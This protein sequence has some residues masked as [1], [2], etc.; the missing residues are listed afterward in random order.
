MAPNLKVTFNFED[1]LYQI[2]FIWKQSC[3]NT[4]INNYNNIKV[5]KFSYADNNSGIHVN[6]ATFDETFPSK[7]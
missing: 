5:F 4:L 2:F 1:T 6:L 3:C 7:F